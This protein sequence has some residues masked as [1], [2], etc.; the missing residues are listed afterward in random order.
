MRGSMT[1]WMS[2][3]WL[4]LLGASLVGTMPAQAPTPVR[5]GTN[6]FKLLVV[7]GKVEILRRGRKIAAAPN[8]PLLVGDRVQTLEL[9]KATIQLSNGTTKQMDEFSVFEV[10][11]PGAQNKKADYNF[12]KGIYYFFHRDKPGE[13][14][15]RTPTVSAV[16]RGTEFILKVD[17]AI[18]TLSLID[19]EVQMTSLADP[20][21]VL[22]LKNGEEG[23]GEQ[24]QK[25]RKTAGILAN[26][27]VQWALYYP[28][29]LDLDDLDLTGAEKNLLNDS[30]AAYQ[31]GDLLQAVEKY[32]DGRAPAS[33]AERVYRA[34][35]LLAVGRVEKA[36]AMLQTLTPDAAPANRS[37]PSRLGDALRQGIAAVKFQTWPGSRAPA[38]ATE[39]LAESYYQQSLSKLAEAREAAYRAVEKSPKFGFAWAHLA[40]IEFGFGHTEEALR[41]LNVALQL[42]PRNAEA[43]S[44]QGFLLSSQDKIDAAIT[45]FDRAIELDGALGNA[46]LGR[47]LCKMRQ[48]RSE[49]GRQDMQVAATLEPQRALFRSYLAKAFSQTGDDR[50]A[51]SEIRLARQLDKNDPTSWLYSALIHQQQN[52]VNEA[53]DE[54]QQSSAL[55]DNRGVYRSR[56]LLDQDRAVRSANLAA[57]FA[58]AGL[59][60]VAVR[61]AARAV[62]ADYANFSAHLFLA[63]SYNNRRIDTQPTNIR[64]ETPAVSEFLLANL[65]GPAGAGTLSPTVSQQEYSRLFDGPRAGFASATEYLSRGDWTESA[66]QYG[67]F[68]T[69][70]YALEAFHRSL[71]GQQINNDLRQTSL[72]FQFKQQLTPSDSIYLQTIYTDTKGGDLAAYYDP[73]RANP[74]LRFKETQEP[75]LLAGYHHEWAP[76]VHTLFLAGRLQD[77]Q[78]VTDPNYRPLV[79]VRTNGLGP[80]GVG[81]F[82]PTG[83]FSPP[84]TFDQDYRSELNIYT[85]EAQQIFQS[86]RHS[87]VLGGRW[88]GGDFDTRSVLT[89][90]FFIGA[91]AAGN[92]PQQFGT[93][94]ERINFYGY[95]SWRLFQPLTLVGGVSYDR[96]RYPENFRFAP[97]SPNERTTD[98]VSPKAGLV[99]TPADS[100]TV[101]AAW[102]RSLGGVSFDQ[103]F[104]LEPTQVAGINQAFRSIIPDGVAAAQSAARFETWGVALEQK[105]PTRTY[106]GVSAELL[107]S[108]VDAVVGTFDLD[109]PPFAAFAQSSTP[110]TLDYRERSVSVTANQ[111]VGDEWSFGA[112]YRLSEAKLHA[113]LPG[114]PSAAVPGAD[115]QSKA[116]LHQVNL[117]TTYNHACGFFTQGEAVWYRQHNDDNLQTLAGDEFWQFNAFVG[118]RFP[119]RI[120]EARVGLLN[121]FDHDYRLNPLNLANELPRHRT[122]AASFRFNF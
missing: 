9:S 12:F 100:T 23:V 13:Y 4:V 85:A 45:R 41:A 36:E 91:F 20:A 25:L 71:N 117:F 79:F 62:S 98:K 86:E 49:D 47:G 35:L 92:P 122:I 118:Y 34:A 46:W 17:D 103:S 82:P 97:V 32:P 26:N 66:V 15:I 56:L 60:D 113:L 87:T 68:G 111:L 27:L 3:T 50:H 114:I 83:A 22:T 30:L 53:I 2:V 19:G 89:P 40:E 99:W 77:Q 29:V 94:F 112:S 39:W 43:V 57:I 21:D 74:G 96:L 102:T 80:A 105:L 24:G 93:D 33:D 106:L 65:L 11:P 31:A 73:A 10:A 107:R 18:T 8:D 38:L 101:R 48:G 14:Q 95:H 72:S 109:G 121:I 104:R 78:S 70:S 16:V 54:L 55:N 28:G 63:D 88:Q 64:Y 58:D 116:L 5:A 69:F 42:A 61:E 76:G 108:K 120:A 84:A 90:L 37:A 51:A 7:V 119:R 52:R 67:N 75:I 6:D 81:P 1:K 44:L 115:Q 59:A 110:Q